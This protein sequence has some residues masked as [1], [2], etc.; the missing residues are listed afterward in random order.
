MN[1]MKQT[2]S[3]C[4]IHGLF[5]FFRGKNKGYYEKYIME[6]F[7]MNLSKYY[8]RH[9]EEKAFDDEM[10]SKVYENGTKAEMILYI[11]NQTILNMLRHI[12]DEL[13]ELKKKQ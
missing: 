7:L 1:L 2:I 12:E 4:C 13:Q 6:V 8:A 5:V 10:R 11:Q 9:A 3:P